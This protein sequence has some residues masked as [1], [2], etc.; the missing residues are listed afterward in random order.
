MHKLTSEEISEE[1]LDKYIPREIKLKY[2]L[3]RKINEQ[4]QYNP[5]IF[6][7]VNKGDYNF[8]NELLKYHIFH[9]C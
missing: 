4:F 8:I 9:Y 5:D 7:K 2:K 1:V 6:N 3:I